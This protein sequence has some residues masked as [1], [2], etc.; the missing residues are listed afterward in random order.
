MTAGKALHNCHHHLVLVVGKVGFGKL[1]S[2]LELAGRDLVMPSFYG[3]S[4]PVEFS[5]DI[6]HVGKNL[7]VD[8]SEVMV[9]HLLSF[10]RLGSAKGVS[11]EDDVRPKAGF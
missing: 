6:F 8:G 2:K 3:D 5:L 11:A 1:G 7:R 4:Q 10:C 9:L